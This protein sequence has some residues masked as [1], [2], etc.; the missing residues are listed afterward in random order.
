[1]VGRIYRL[2]LIAGLSCA[3]IAQLLNTKRRLAELGRPWTG[4]RVRQ[5]LTS[6][7]YVGV[8]VFGKIRRRLDKPPQRQ[9]SAAWLRVPGAFAPLVAPE[10]FRAAQAQMR[11]PKLHATDEQLL[12]GP[13]DLLAREGRL[14]AGLINRAEVTQCVS[15]YQRRFGTLM[16]TYDRVGYRPSGRQV[17]AARVIRA[18][19]PHLDRHFEPDLSD[20]ELLT[21]LADLLARTEGLSVQAI[22]AA[23][24][25]PNGTK[26][27]SRFGGMRRAYALVGFTPTGAQAHVLALCGG[28]SITAEAAAALAQAVRRG[29]GPAGFPATARPCRMEACPTNAAMHVR[30]S[31]PAIF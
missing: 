15:V 31:R 25:L 27:S 30:P 13:A 3:G 22:N 7:K 21:R 28:Q 14:S 1:M 29:G 26:Y 23:P 24:D 5:V 12:A 6:K 10:M 19:L 20:D 18:R 2:F 8:N 17:A 16:D 4:H 11:H 9:Q